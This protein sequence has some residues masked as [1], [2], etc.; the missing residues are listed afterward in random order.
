M[1]HWIQF[2]WNYEE[3][4]F[5]EYLKER[6]ITVFNKSR[7]VITSVHY[8]ESGMALKHKSGLIVRVMTRFKNYENC[9]TDYLLCSKSTKNMEQMYLFDPSTDYKSALKINGISI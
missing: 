1:T 9:S 3:S 8:L 5:Q 4:E 7:Q 2:P 6:E